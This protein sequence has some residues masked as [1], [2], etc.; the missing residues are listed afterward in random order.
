MSEETDKVLIPASSFTGT[1]SPTQPRVAQ[2]FGDALTA[3]W[4]GSATGLALRGKLPDVVLDPQHAP[5][6]HKLA[7]GGAQMASELPEMVGGAALGGLAGIETGPGAVVTAGAGAFAVP[8]ALR[9]SLMQAYTKG[10]VVNAADFWTRTKIVLGATA[11]DAAIGGVS[12]GVGGAVGKLA[13]P[14]IGEGLGKVASVGAELGTMTTMPAAMEGRMPEPEDF[15]N[16]AILA[17][18]MH[19]ATGAAS[20]LREIYAKTNIPPSDVLAMAKQDPML[21]HELKGGETQPT[22]ELWGRIVANSETD[23]TLRDGVLNGQ[24]A[25]QSQR[26]SPAEGSGLIPE[27]ERRALSGAGSEDGGSAT[28]SG[29]V[30]VG[31]GPERTLLRDDQRLQE[32]QYRNVP[33]VVIG[34]TEIVAAPR[35]PYF[36]FHGNTL[37]DGVPVVSRGSG[38]VAGDAVYIGQTHDIAGRFRGPEGPD[39][40]PGGQV[41]SLYIDTSKY[42]A[43]DLRINREYT[44][45]EL[46]ALG[47][48]SEGKPY[49]GFEVHKLLMDMAE[50]DPATFTKMTKE[51]GFNGVGYGLD[52]MGENAP[53][54]SVFD[55]GVFKRVSDTRNW[56]PDEIAR[57]QAFDP[58]PM[59]VVGGKPEVPSSLKPVATA[60]AIRDAF[61]GTPAQAAE[62]QA[63]PFANA[64]ENRVPYT[65]NTSFLTGP[66]EVTGLINK[67]VETYQQN[68]KPKT[69][70]E[71]RAGSAKLADLLGTDSQGLDKILQRFGNMDEHMDV[72]RDLMLKVAVDAS[73]ACKAVVEAGLGAT[74]AMRLEAQEAI[75]RAAMVKGVVEGNATDIARALNSL[76]IVKDAA[77]VGD[78][79]KAI[80]DQFGHDPTKAIEMVAQIDSPEGTNRA[81]SKITKASTWQQVMEGWKAGLLGPTTVIKK[82]LSD[83]MQVV[84]RPLV[85][86]MAPMFAKDAHFMDPIIGVTHAVKGIGDALVQGWHVLKSEVPVNGM[87]ESR[88]AIPGVAGEVIRTPFRAIEAVTEVFK[89][90]QQNYE[91]GV[92]ASRAALNEFHL[93]PRT[94]E[95]TDKVAELYANPPEAWM[96]HL[97]ETGK[98]FT[99]SA[100]LGEFGKRWRRVVNTAIS[101][102]ETKGPDGKPIPGTGIAPLQI[103]FPFLK[104][105]LNVFEESARLSPLAFMSGEWRAAVAEGGT[106]RARAIA[107]TTIGTGIAALGLSWAAGNKITGAGDPDPAKR[108]VAVAAG[109]Q[110]YSVKVG[111]QW[112]SYKNFHP[113][114]TLLGMTADFHM[115]SEFMSADEADKASKA[116]AAAFAHA[117]TEQTFLQG[118]SNLVQALD[119]PEHKGQVFIQNLMASAVPATIVQTSAIFHK[120]PYKRQVD[121]ILDAVQA[122]IP[123]LR[124]SLNPQV[125]PWGMPMAN[126]ERVAAVSPILTR[127]LSMD[128]VRT[129]AARLGIGAKAAPKSV[130]LPAFGDRE[131][132]KVELDAN[133]RLEFGTVA[134]KTAYDIMKPMVTSDMWGSIPDFAK[135]RMFEKALAMGHKMGANAAITPEQRKEEMQRITEEIAAKLGR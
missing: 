26:S 90:Y 119:S 33:S 52:A 131:L 130:N 47:I 18:G 20:K 49:N 38:N 21:E 97:D 79:I 68:Q 13:T 80:W 71:T 45:K 84:A 58:T 115:M 69:F 42:R 10:S 111:D 112:V 30:D 98:R 124:E 93:D 40:T 34:G 117:V 104:A 83:I 1:A 46:L 78:P 4:Q 109:W 134:G 116:M 6:Y 125:D 133:Q 129:E 8:T 28:G 81:I 59:K 14:L 91:R 122:R 32:Y 2:D 126:D 88:G 82:S 100:D 7:A 132:G 22:E 102:T 50:N 118:M 12:A 17:V 43:L 123:G 19:A 51:L 11:K 37:T 76:K 106:A 60:Q 87:T 27:S 25:N 72:L 61:P 74:D 94:K 101:G 9:E 54:W 121:S 92:M 89:T 99:Y 70:A 57:R 23:P 73:A 48:D 3:G 103:V 77:A 55:P 66:N 128:P 29:R 56:T 64:P 113:V 41:L 15:M 127:G 62:V 75:Q 86:T 67:M 107:E 114:G 5:W 39:G 110:P 108:R 135:T 53:A 95:F 24:E 16:A 65:L 63:N 105:P 96:D 120:D 44:P 35:P 85:D 31:M 36:S